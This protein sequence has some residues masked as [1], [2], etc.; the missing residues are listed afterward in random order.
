LKAR[1]LG[2][3][4]SGLARASNATKIDKWLQPFGLRR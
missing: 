1:V 4:R 3:T 2:D